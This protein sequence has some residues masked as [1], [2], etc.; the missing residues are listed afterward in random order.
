[1]PN[2]A[3]IQHFWGQEIPVSSL[4]NFGIIDTNK[5]QLNHVCGLFSGYHAMHRHA[6]SVLNR[7]ITMDFTMSSACRR[8]LWGVFADAYLAEARELGH[9]ARAFSPTKFIV[10]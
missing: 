3:C 6:Q 10:F 9:A 1:M 4:M 5:D 8:L 2:L 7:T